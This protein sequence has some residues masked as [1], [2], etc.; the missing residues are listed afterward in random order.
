LKETTMGWR[1][2][3]SGNE[4]GFYT[5]FEQHAALGVESATELVALVEGRAD[6][7]R[8]T[9]RIKQI[10]GA[11]D[12]VTHRCIEELHKVFT[13]PL[14][15][16]H[17]HRLISRLDDVVDFV[18]AAADRI[19]LYELKEMTPDVQELARIVLR[20]TE[21]VERAVRSLRD[22]KNAVAL[23]ATCAEIDALENDADARLRLALARLLKERDRLFVMKWKEV[24]ELLETVT[25][26]CEDVANTLEGIVLEH[27]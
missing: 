22:R 11:A 15:R 24:Y 2:F 7:N 8:A 16:G 12:V 26:R 20:A 19:G 6:V 4:A 10:E 17:V 13:T 1:Q 14:G 3:F 18:E 27:A 5:A 23:L 25:D 9:A 21:A